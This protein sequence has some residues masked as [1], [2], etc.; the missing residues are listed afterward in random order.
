VSRIRAAAHRLRGWL[1]RHA[2]RALTLVVAMAGLSLIVAGI[3]LIYLPAGFIATGL[4]LFAGL[5]FD[6]AAVRKLTWPR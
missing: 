3:A 4:A 1:R 2:A 5:M 6:P